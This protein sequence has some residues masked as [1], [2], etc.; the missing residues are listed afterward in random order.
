[1][2][3]GPSV[4]NN[5]N[6]APNYGPGALNRQQRCPSSAAPKRLFAGWTYS[7]RPGSGVEPM[8]R[9]PTVI[10]LAK[11]WSYY[12]DCLSTRRTHWQRSPTIG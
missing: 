3:G 10:G 5:A 7:A 12:G 9:S 4:T 1:M 8:A 6:G 2:T 11:R